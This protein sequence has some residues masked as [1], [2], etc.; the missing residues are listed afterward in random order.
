VSFDNANSKVDGLIKQ[1]DC[2]RKMLTCETKKPYFI[3]MED[4]WWKQLP[5]I[6]RKSYV[7]KAS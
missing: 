6:K 1:L 4:S 5:V 3:W 7:W 2:R